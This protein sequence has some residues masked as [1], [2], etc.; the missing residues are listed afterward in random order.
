MTTLYVTH[1]QVEAMTLGD[2]IAVLD[3]AGCSSSARRTRCS[4]QPANLFVA[5]FMGSPPMNLMRGRAEGAR[6]SAGTLRLSAAGVPDGEVVV[7]F[8]P[9]ALSL[10][11]GALEMQV[12]VVEPLGTET[13]V[14]GSIDGELV[15]PEDVTGEAT[16]LPALAGARASI[17]ARLGPRERPT[18]GERV[19]LALDFDAVHLFDARTGR[20]LRVTTRAA[21][22]RARCGSSRPAPPSSALAAAAPTPRATAPA[23]SAPAA[24]AH[25]IPARHASPLPT[26]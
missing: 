11:A 16:E 8:R 24:S 6:L 13:L 7:G 17:A 21:S 5:A 19:S 20:A 22:A 3:A 15:R 26:G 4:T 14:H 9:E 25:T 23:Q 18:V 12:E 10:G 2:R 1:D